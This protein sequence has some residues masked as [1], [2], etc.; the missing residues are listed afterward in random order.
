M[1]KTKKPASGTVR[2]AAVIAA[3]ALSATPLTHAH[4][5]DHEIVSPQIP[6]EYVEGFSRGAHAFDHENVH[7]LLC[8]KKDIREWSEGNKTVIV[9]YQKRGGELTCCK[10]K[11]TPTKLQLVPLDETAIPEGAIALLS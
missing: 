2:K 10:I 7:T 4:I 6:E 1:A 3:V 9:V 5:I 8:R 11:I